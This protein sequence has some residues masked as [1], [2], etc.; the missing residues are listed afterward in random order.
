[1]RVS[2][3]GVNFQPYK[4]KSIKEKTLIPTT[5]GAGVSTR[6][7]PR[8]SVAFTCLYIDVYLRKYVVTVI[9]RHLDVTSTQ[10]LFVHQERGGEDTCGFYSMDDVIA[11]FIDITGADHATAQSLLEVE[12]CPCEV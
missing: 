6:P 2:Q 1:M 7:C 5:E 10:R 8:D 4:S 3:L 9:T 11:N 12:R